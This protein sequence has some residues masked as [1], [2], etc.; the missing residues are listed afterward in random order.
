[1][2]LSNPIRENAKKT[3]G[4]FK[5]QG[6]AVKVISGDNPET[7]SEVA[8]CAG[9]EH[10]EKYVDAGTLDTDEKIYDAADRYTAGSKQCAAFCQPVSG[11]KYILS[12]NGNLCSGIDNYLSVRAGTDFPHQYVYHW[13]TGI[14]TGIGAKPQPY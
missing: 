4:Y 5:T 14:L 2:I 9:I 6:V 11:K 13:G 8:R 3:F 1:M 10:A 7:V 12:V